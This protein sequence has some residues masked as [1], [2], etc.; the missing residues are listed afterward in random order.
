MK[1]TVFLCLSSAFLAAGFTVC[2]VQNI[3]AAKSA[4]AAGGTLPFQGSPNRQVGPANFRVSNMP[5]SSQ[6]LQERKFS[7]EERTNIAVYD[8]VNPSVVNIDTKAHQRDELWFLG[9]SGRTREGS[10]SGWVLDQQGHI[11]TNYHVIEGSDLISVTLSDFDEPFPAEV[12]GTDPQNDIAV[13]QIK[14]P[15]ALLKPV[16]LG[17][18]SSLKV[19]QKI[20]AIGNPFGLQS[21]MTVGI[22]SSLGRSLRSDNGRLIKNVIQI[23]AALNQGN[24]GGPLLDS[25]GALVGM[26]TAIASL[27][28]E[29]TGV[30][31][32][33]PVNT[34]KRVIPQLLEFGEVRRATLGID[35]FWKS[36][37]GIGVA[38]PERYGPAEAAGIRGL[39]VERKL[40]RV[41]NRVFEQVSYD[42]DAAD[43]IL[44]IENFPIESTDDLQD[45]LDQFKP[46]QTVG[47]RI[48]RNNKEI[49]L[50]V[51]LGLER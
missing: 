3:P 19:G 36:E 31:F 22:V 34:I 21:T 10:G 8:N 17:E 2:L 11:V 9:S 47:V 26:N 14:A 32:S 43:R 20:F 6:P 46:G 27:T 13:L 38:R 25:E 18:S 50:P 45:A 49:T 7:P 42:K 41:G 16:S 24:S 40:V 48:L 29:N 39:K 28:G 4:N 30:G 15:A 1:S 44:A 35:L 51:T 5:G 33:I 23:D 12:I 37:S